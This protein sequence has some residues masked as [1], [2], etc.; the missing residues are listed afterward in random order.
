MFANAVKAVAVTLVG[1]AGLLL[2]GCGSSTGRV[3]GSPQLHPVR[4]EVRQARRLLLTKAELRRGFD[5]FDSGAS[6]S[7]NSGYCHDGP[8]L[9]ALSETA[10]MYGAGLVNGD[11]RV[12]YVPSAYVF[13]SQAQAARAERGY[14][15]PDSATCAV[16]LVKQRLK[17]A[18]AKI[19]AQKLL[20][21]QRRIGAVTVKARRAILTVTIQGLKFRME[22]SLIFFLRGRAVVEVWTV[23]PWDATTRRT[24]EAAV[25]V[26]AR[27]INDSEL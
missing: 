2:A 11:L 6:P 9:S 15:A 13:V 21:V 1:V 5:T 18:S 19:D 22:A 7:N 25:G 23:G 14:T 27:N 4:A 16:V 24:W 8:D 3:Q 17:G 26:V 20:F 12:F 10:E